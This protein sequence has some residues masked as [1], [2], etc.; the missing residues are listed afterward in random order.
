M[1]FR[2]KRDNAIHCTQKHRQFCCLASQLLLWHHRDGNVWPLSNRMKAFLLH[3][4]GCIYIM[5]WKGVVNMMYFKV[6]FSPVHSPVHHMS[7]PHWYITLCCNPRFDWTFRLYSLKYICRA[8]MLLFHLSLIVL[9]I[10]NGCN[11]SGAVLF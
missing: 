10:A 7:M 6:S 2:E 4:A 9:G 11:L 1:Q 5:I 8:K 3:L